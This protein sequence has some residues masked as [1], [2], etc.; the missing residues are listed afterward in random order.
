MSSRSIAVALVA[1]FAGAPS[2]AAEKKEAKARDCSAE[3]AP[4]G[5]LVLRIDD[6][7]IP[8]TVARMRSQ[9]EMSIGEEPDQESFEVFAFSLR[10]DESIFPAHE[11]SVS[12]M[13]TKGEKLDGKSF[14]RLPIDDMQKQPTPVKSEGTWMPEVQSVE[15]ASEPDGIEYEH[16][17]LSS[18]RVD[19]G[20]RK[21]EALPVK[22]R[23][24]IAPGQTDST[25]LPE[26]TRAI[27]VEGAFEAKEGL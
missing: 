23:L 1:L 24:C 3:T 10:D 12:V 9:Q 15:V 19:V 21:G 2:F 8:L 14:R 7:S 11:V 20:E 25:F 13:V 17:V 6:A 5:P 26:P 16:G 4:D 18:V 27:V 22:L